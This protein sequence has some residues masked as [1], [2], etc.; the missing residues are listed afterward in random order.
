M[1]HH[2]Q[3]EVKIVTFWKG[4]FL[5]RIATFQDQVIVVAHHFF[6]PYCYN[7]SMWECEKY[8]G[9]LVGILMMRKCNL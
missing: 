7:Y 5:C 9:P 1:A 3:N 2:F 8:G 6:H 4:Y